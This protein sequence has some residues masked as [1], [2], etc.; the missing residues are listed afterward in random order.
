MNKELEKVLGELQE[1]EK[2][3]PKE[4]SKEKVIQLVKQ[5]SKLYGECKDYPKQYEQVLRLLE[6]YGSQYP[7]KDPRL[8]PY[9]EQ[10]LEL[11]EL[12]PQMPNQLKQ[13]LYYKN[14]IV[15]VYQERNKEMKDKR[16]DKEY[17]DEAIIASTYTQIAKLYIQIENDYQKAIESIETAIFHFQKKYGEEHQIIAQSLFQISKYYIELMDLETAHTYA[18]KSYKMMKKTAGNDNRETALCVSNLAKIQRLRENYNEAVQEERRALE[19]FEKYHRN[20]AHSDIADA[21]IRLAELYEITE[22]YEKA[23]ELQEKSLSMNRKLHGQENIPVA[24]SLIGI[25]KSL[26]HLQNHDEAMKYAEASVHMLKNVTGENSLD[27]AYG[28][29]DLTEIYFAGNYF[30]EASQKQQI[31]IQIFKNHNQIS[32]VVQMLC[33]YASTIEKLE[34]YDQQIEAIKEALFYLKQISPENDIKVSTLV[35]NLAHLLCHHNKIEEAIQ[36][37]FEALQLRINIFGK[38]TTNVASTYEVLSM[39]FQKANDFL[40][41][42][43]CLE[44]AINIYSVLCEERGAHPEWARLL[45][46]LAEVQSELGEYLQAIETQNKS[47]EMIESLFS[48]QHPLY[49]SG[50]VNLSAYYLE[51]NKPEKSLELIL[52]G[53]KLLANEYGE[54]DINLADPYE[55]LSKIYTQLGYMGLATDYQYKSME[56]NKRFMGERHEVVQQN[57]LNL[58]EIYHRQRRYKESKIIKDKVKIINSNMFFI[59]PQKRI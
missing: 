45:D 4:Y 34:L 12:Q 11:I 8:L 21:L 27:Y 26:S 10:I 46:N 18:D 44:E 43:E 53:I 38:N 48:N 33:K 49:A 24:N 2:K 30:V 47:L 35:H 3:P 9:Y 5:L 13:I 57:M 19:I 17:I 54:D 29:R 42:E 56:I 6:Y 28:M 22:E 31:I 23:F 14:K 41:S 40:K 39:I 25:A 7:D 58:A 59:T 15:V 50:L 36:Y 16:S 32:D 55:L 20:K 1:Q 37:G 52:Q 51:M